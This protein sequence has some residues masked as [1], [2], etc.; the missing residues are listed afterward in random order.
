LGLCYQIIRWAQHISIWHLIPNL[1]TNKTDRHPVSDAARRAVPVFQMLPPWSRA[2]NAK[3]ASI[4][5]A[6]GRVRHL[7]GVWRLLPTA[8]ATQRIGW[9]AAGRMPP[10]VSR[11]VSPALSD[12]S[13][14]QGRLVMCMRQ[15]LLLPGLL[16]RIR[17]PSGGQWGITHAGRVL[18]GPRQPLSCCGN[19]MNLPEV[20]PPPPSNK[21]I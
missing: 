4:I 2:C 21:N 20:F 8:A 11:N 13:R 15:Q 1:S 14:R 18:T 12:R 3:V 9:L 6:R 19:P 17:R 5:R 10:R 16:L 7:I